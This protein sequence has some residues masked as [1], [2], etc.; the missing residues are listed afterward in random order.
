MM[1][2]ILLAL[3]LSPVAVCHGSAT[4]S[5]SLHA[6]LI[7]DPE[8]D[9]PLAY[10]AGKRLAD[11][12]VGE[13]RTV[14]LFYFLP[15]DRPFR[16][17]VVQRMK[18]EIL[19]IQAWYGE[20]MEAHGY[21]YKTF[22]V[23]TDDDG[24]PVVH[25]VDGQHPD[26]HYLDSW[27][28]I[29]DETQ[30]AF[31]LSRSIVAVV[32][33]NSNN[34]LSRRAVGTASLGGKERGVALVTAEFLWQTLAHELA[35][36][37]AQASH[38]DFRSE[39]YILSYG[40][41]RRD[42]LSA[43]SAEVIAVHPYFN[44]DV[45]LEWGGEE[46]AIH[47]LSAK[48]YPEGSES[49]PIRLRVSDVDGIQQVRL[50]VRTGATNLGG[51]PSGGLELKTC[52]GLMGAE[53]AVVEID[54]DGVIP[55]GAAFH[56]LSDPQV[57]P[58]SIQVVDREGNRGAPLHS[59]LWEVSRQHLATFEEEEVRGVVFVSGGT[60]LA[61]ASRG[62][63]KL[64]NLETRTGT[65]TRLEGRVSLALSADGAI[66][67]SGSTHGQIQ[68]LDLANDR[69][70]ATF[71]SGHT[72]PIRSLAFSSDGTVLASGAPDGIRLWA[73]GTQTRTATLPVGVTSMALSPNG[74]TLASASEDGVRLWDVATQTEIA[75][76]SHSR[77]R[78]GPEVNTVAFSPDGALVASG[79]LDA[80]VR[81]W[82]VATGENIAVF[83][84]EWA[85]RTVVFSPDGNLLASGTR[86]VVNLWDPRTKEKLAHLRG[87]G[88][89][90]T[91][92]AFSSDGTTL[93]AGAEDGKIGLWDVSEWL[94]PRPR[95]LVMI[96]GDDQQATDS[97]PLAP[98]VVEVRDQ[99]GHP[100]PD[101]EITFAVTRGQGKVG[102]RF[103]EK[104][105]L[106]DA[107][108]RAEAILT[109]GP[110]PNTVEVSVEGLEVLTFRS[111][112]TD[113]P[114]V[115]GDSL[116]PLPY[117]AF[118][119]LGKGRLTWW[120]DP[121]IAFSPSGALL[122]VGTET[123]GIWL[124]DVAA[125]QEAAWLPA[126]SVLGLAFSP[127]GQTVAS[128]AD[129]EDP[130]IRLWDVA[131]GDQKAAIEHQLN[132]R[133]LAFSPDGRTLA[134]G[135]NWGLELWEVE[136][137]AQIAAVSEAEGIWEIGSVAFSP[138]GSTLAAGS[139]NDDSV[140]L[141]DVAAF[142]RTATFD[143]HAGDVTAVAFSPDGRT[144]ASASDDHT[145][146]LWDV[147]TASEIATFDGHGNRVNA[148][149]FSPDGRTVASGSSDGWDGRVHLWDV[150]TG[151]DVTL[152]GHEGS[153]H[154]VAFSRDGTVASASGD[155]TVRLWD[156]ATRSSTTLSRQHFG[157]PHWVA[158]SPGGTTL[159]T[160]LPSSNAVHLWDAATGA[161]DAVL[162]GHTARLNV[163]AFSP[164]GTTLASGA[165]D[166]TV[167][168][169]DVS[170]S[171]HIATFETPRYVT[172]VTFS[173]DGRL[174]ASRHG[175][176]TATVWDVAT[177]E[178]VAAFQGQVGVPGFSPDGSTLVAALEDG[179]IELWDL[180]SGDGILGGESLG[181]R[182]QAVSFSP[183]GTALALGWGSG[184]ASIWE[185][186]AGADAATLALDYPSPRI[187]AAAFSPDGS[188]LLS[189]VQSD[190]SVVVEVRDV[191]TGTLL[192]APKGH[193]GEVERLAFS[194]DGSTF[195][196]SSHDATILVWD[197]GL[198]LP[199]PQ[200]LAGLSG[201][202]QEGF[203]D[204]PL[205]EALVV[206]VMDQYDDP[207][208][209]A[210][211]T[212]AVTGGGGTVSRETATTDAQGQAST[213]LT[214]GQAPGPNT[215]AVTAGDLEPVIFTAL[216]QSVPT[217]LSK[218]GGD[219]QQ[220]ASGS[221][222]A[223]PLVVS[224]L[225]QA[226]E[227]LAGATAT[228]AVT[229][230]QGTLSVTRTTT[231][232]QGRAASTLTPGR[233]PG[234]NT[235]E[236]TVA[237]LAPVTFTALGRAIPQTLTKL[238]G[239]EQQGEPGTPLGEALAVSVQD[240]N[241]AALP[242][243]VVSFAV[244]G[245]GGTLSALT[246]T[247]DAEGRAATTLTLGEEFG[248]YTVVVTVTGLEPVTFTVTA[249]SSP[250]FDDDG[251]VGFS[252]FFLFAEHFGG[253]DPRFDLD[254]SG[255]VDFNDFFLFAEH[256]GQP[257]RA[258]LVALARELIGLPDGPQLR[259]NAPN[260]FNSGTVISWFQLEPGMAHLEVFALTG[261]RVAVLHRGPKRAGLHRLR[262]DGR[263]ERGRLLASGVYVY[264]LVTAEA[265]QT[266]KLTLLR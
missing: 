99:Y 83:E 245:D 127:D 160:A 14:R 175:G 172:A 263:D 119:R 73:V 59:D 174:V 79:G 10:T 194:R 257:A 90:G 167:R 138:D 238:S 37:F 146:K 169:W 211:V 217:T 255:S 181:E 74:A 135:S 120:G 63:V 67:A 139:R 122:A 125:L 176:G 150:A 71:S 222:L 32:V 78:W 27:V 239:D 49:V 47:L 153:V 18:E 184:T 116:R 88:R 58:I 186:P 31:D 126:P 45:R 145:V 225:D 118:N 25:R 155:A 190:G 262:W 182:I 48:A 106:S 180:A 252:D 147:A 227:P 232:A 117:G 109:P 133:S 98:L 66:L 151:Q 188:L 149:A 204:A 110:G 210:E 69:V 39:R 259:Q 4:S 112:G 137:G 171:T 103:T 68:L 123:A 102:D 132:P 81:L 256:F 53:E 52:R 6:C 230:G 95:S 260:P 258:R 237:G 162:E 248:T 114:P 121:L 38:H 115:V 253:S 221:P 202:G 17:E 196:S 129:W 7:L 158:L 143:G 178:E 94:E 166:R 163:V 108:G 70:I 19:H 87:E 11:L 35:H 161:L 191:A 148:L 101:V 136:T 266:R 21:G 16:P 124:Y 41:S 46:S 75:S 3:T 246:D 23:E 24:D 107:R 179:R 1:K 201:D 229:G 96:S 218:V 50:V 209:G 213:T 195:A 244:L 105:V 130:W 251:E 189:G 80:T 185:V 65:R 64:W 82:E 54:Y 159:A 214:L 206:V 254:G 157:T 193:S 187:D 134:S 91:T 240:Q 20:Q 177:G 142:T 215:V 100:L 234:I 198:T 15:N 40:G 249:K 2:G 228:F 236:V 164:D 62:G 219:A 141:W 29:R 5:D 44:P 72:H 12:N 216:T 140:T 233:T 97:E 131:T 212:F 85:V 199:H 111:A 265:V 93:A 61:F 207:L 36:I 165:S 247:T 60:T 33:D 43:C 208:A 173:A 113:M 264:R 92:V 250:D 55:S 77:D 84:H 128:C 156:V 89:G 56:D 144:V 183:D 51:V 34:L 200:T 261:Q 13:P 242:G 168:L 205:D 154:A 220:G 26:S 42:V 170:T 241:G 9:P 224:L 192:A 226:G 76:Y 197:L 28:I 22:R 8:R 86:H 243:A 231:D 203:P 223:E 235:V 57:H 30:S 104:R 152:D